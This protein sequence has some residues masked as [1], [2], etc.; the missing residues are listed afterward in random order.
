M[1]Q[2]QSRKSNPNG[3]SVYDGINTDTPSGIPIPQRGTTTERGTRSG[4]K[5]NSMFPPSGPS[6][7]DQFYG[8]PG[9]KSG[10]SNVAKRKGTSSNYAMANSN[11]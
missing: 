3:R 10:Y 4:I 11:K 7:N 6:S 5:T 9:Q 1:S 8:A 2:G